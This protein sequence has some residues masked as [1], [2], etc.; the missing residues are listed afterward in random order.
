MCV[1]VAHRLEP[2][3]W[4]TIAED[5]AGKCSEPNFPG[6]LLEWRLKVLIDFLLYS[7]RFS[8]YVHIAL[9]M[10]KKTEIR[11]K[12]SKLAGGKGMG[13]KK[14]KKMLIFF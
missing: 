12:S 13:K 14:R 11:Y 8:L 3:S 4:V 9:V 5:M 2:K 7:I 6:S 1:G 10:M